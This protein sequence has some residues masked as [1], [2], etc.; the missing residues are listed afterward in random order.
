[1]L[2]Y[3]LAIVGGYAALAGIVLAGFSVAL[4]APHLAFQSD[5]LNVTNN[6][7]IY[8]L[9]LSLAAAVV[10]GYVCKVIGRCDKIVTL[11]AV[12]A[13]A[14][15]IGGAVANQK[16]P[17]PTLAREQIVAMTMMEKSEHLRQPNWYAWTLPFVALGGIVAGGRLRKS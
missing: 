16:K 12:I 2:R 13:M 8:T 14:V 5:S 1:M 15:G 7:I 11:F 17:E 6:W 9:I 10:G 3:V 4:F